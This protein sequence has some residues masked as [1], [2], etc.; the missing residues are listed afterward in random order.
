[1]LRWT[2]YAKRSSLHKIERGGTDESYG[3]EVAKLAGVPFEVVARARDLLS[4]LEKANDGK[5]KLKIRRNAR[6]MDGQI[7]LFS[8]SLALRRY[9]EVIERLQQMDVQK[10]TPLDALNALYELSREAQKIELKG[11]S[12]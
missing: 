11:E 6:P 2:S 12:S 3:I 9:D 8:S 5:A 4:M 7:D 1:M 10:M